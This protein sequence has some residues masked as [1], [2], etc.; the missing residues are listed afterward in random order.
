MERYEREK[1]L[2]RYWAN[3]AD[4]LRGAAGAV[5]FAIQDGSKSYQ[6]H[7]MI[8]MDTSFSFAAACPS[9]FRMLCGLSLELLYKALIIEIGKD[10]PAT[11]DLRKLSEHAQIAMSADDLAL[12]DILT[13]HIKWAG[14]YP[15]PKGGRGE[16]DKL[17][18]R[19]HAALTEPVP[20]LSIGAFRY[21]QRLDWV[22]YSRIWS[23]GNSRYFELHK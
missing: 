16:W 11:H 13:D 10:P 3:R 17:S 4:D 5:W 22:D 14:K 20:N 1:A 21:N 15:V 12:I 2:S 18:D 8:G 19:M 6:I 7:R 23:I 9:V